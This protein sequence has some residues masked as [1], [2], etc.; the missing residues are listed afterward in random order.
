MADMTILLD[1]IASGGKIAKSMC[2]LFGFI[3]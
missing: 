2:C 3:I 1:V